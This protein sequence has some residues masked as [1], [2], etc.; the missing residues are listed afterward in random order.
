MGGKKKKTKQLDLY[1]KSILWFLK[2]GLIIQF[3][4]LVK[5]ASKWQTG[6]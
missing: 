4:F 1:I 3:E 6:Q 5:F 2:K